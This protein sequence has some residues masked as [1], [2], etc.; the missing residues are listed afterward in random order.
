MR[1]H[2]ELKWF[3]S[4]HSNDQGG[5]CVE[6]ARLPG[7]AGIAVRDSKRP[8]GPSFTA[9]SSAWSGFLAGL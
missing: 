8:N 7:A 4:S 6:A 5:N 9:T 3:K 1:S 2:P